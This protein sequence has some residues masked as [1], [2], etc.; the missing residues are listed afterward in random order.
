MN[1][2]STAC[3]VLLFAVGL[4]AEALSKASESF[5]QGRKR[6]AETSVDKNAISSRFDCLPTE[7]KLTDV[8]SY[9]EKRKSGDERVTVEDK[10]TELK[11]RCKD[12]RLISGSGR[13]I[14]FFKFSCFG[15][16]PID[17]DEIAQKERS[18]LEK[19]QKE[20]TVIIIECDPRTN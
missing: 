11:S 7:F 9:G 17:Y 10:L 20:Y 19:L 1:K 5:Q 18:E 8:V 4:Q 12:G 6:K 2:L 16:P 13:E 14:R 3:L 15:N